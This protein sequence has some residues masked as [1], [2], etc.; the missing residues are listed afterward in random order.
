VMRTAP[1]LRDGG[2]ERKDSTSTT[3][4]LFVRPSRR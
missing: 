2:P 3:G 1:A 4:R